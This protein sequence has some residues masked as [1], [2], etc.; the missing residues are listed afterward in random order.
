MPDPDVS[1]VAPAG[2]DEPA[3]ELPARPEGPTR[4]VRRDLLVGAVGLVAALA[5]VRLVSHHATTPTGHA[6]SAPSATAPVRSADVA[7]PGLPARAAGDAAACPG[8]RCVTLASAP[9]RVSAAI[10]AA[11][12]GARTGVAET[13]RLVRNGTAGA[14]WYREVQASAPGRLITLRIEAHGPGD[15]PSGGS[16]D[17]GG[18]TTT[19]YESPRLQWLVR[20]EVQT[21][22]GVHQA[23]PPLIRLAAD[24]R[25]LVA[26]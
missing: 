20:V 12:P 17:D 7:A 23:L 25:V 18:T 13:V 26:S 11:F 21:R 1:F 19:Y 4:R 8:Q 9:S 3:E 6:S 22:S 16:L 24:P 14:L 2:G 15:A 10:A 5:V